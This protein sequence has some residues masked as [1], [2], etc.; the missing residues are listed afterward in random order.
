VSSKAG[1][2][3]KWGKRS[4]LGDLPFL[5]F[6]LIFFTH[7]VILALQLFLLTA[8]DSDIPWQLQNRLGLKI[9]IAID[10][11]LWPRGG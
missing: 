9:A 8:V 7:A 11:V 1:E 5:F 4:S 3:A 6:T 10:E 2:E